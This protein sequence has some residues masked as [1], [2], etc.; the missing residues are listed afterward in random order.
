MEL[1]HVFIAT[2]RG[3]PAA[4]ELIRFGLTEGSGNT[5]PGQGTANR[6]FFFANAML[7]LLWL[8]SEVEARSPAAA[9]LALADR[10]LRTEPS[11]SPFGICFR[12]SPGDVEP[13]FTCWMYR[14][15]YLPE[16]LRIDVSTDAPPTEPL[17][18]HIGFSGRP[19][20]ADSPRREPIGHRAGLREVTALR[21]TTPFADRLSDTALQLCREG[22]V[23]F[24]MGAPHHLEI[25]FD[26][27]RRGKRRDFR[28]DLP[29][30][31]SW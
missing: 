24:D 14:P 7:E 12:P 15:S 23:A 10:C 9:R 2:G 20:R 13:H 18:F 19:D 26:N 21:L 16:H 22:F 3:A 11:V 29:L 6:R 5:H 27:E 8:E 25:G 4:G 17:W 1:D 31:F 30:A 28:P